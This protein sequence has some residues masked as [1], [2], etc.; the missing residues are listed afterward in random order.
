MKKIIVL[1]VSFFL[2]PYVFANEP[3]SLVENDYKTTIKLFMELAGQGNSRA[4]SSLASMYA[5]GEGV[6]QDHQ[7]AKAWFVKSCESGYK[8]ACDEI[9]KLKDKGY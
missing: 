7:Q 1:A 6:K 9:A 3:E 2:S 5:N 8:E 4:Q